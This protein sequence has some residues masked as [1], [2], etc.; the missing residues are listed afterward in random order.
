MSWSVCELNCQSLK[1]MIVVK[2]KGIIKRILCLL[3]RTTHKVRKHKYRTMVMR[4]WNLSLQ[5][6]VHQ[7]LKVDSI[8]SLHYLA[9][10]AM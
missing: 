9:L 5:T 7:Y 6:C 8:V 2:M 3:S 1:S 10:A 4:H